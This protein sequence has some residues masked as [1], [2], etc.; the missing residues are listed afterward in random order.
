MP[1][2]E[3]ARGSGVAA[4]PPGGHGGGDWGAR[5]GGGAEGL[6]GR[7]HGGAGVRALRAGGGRAP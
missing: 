6:S 2:R 7:R 1:A 5:G 4:R 3:V